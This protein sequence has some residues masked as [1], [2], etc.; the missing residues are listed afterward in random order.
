MWLLPATGIDL[1][2]IDSCDGSRGRLR[3][4]RLLGGSQGR[5]GTTEMPFVATWAV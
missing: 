2:Y 1:G 5:L 4:T 3:S